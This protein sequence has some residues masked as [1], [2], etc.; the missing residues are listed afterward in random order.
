MLDVQDSD[1]QQAAY[2]AERVAA[3]AQTQDPGLPPETAAMLAR[4]AEAHLSD[5][6]ADGVPV[7]APELARRLMRSGDVGATPANVVATAAVALQASAG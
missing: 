3:M 6:V 4:Q 2:D 7:E 1:R 5:M